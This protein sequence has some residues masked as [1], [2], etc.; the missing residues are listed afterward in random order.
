MKADM[1]IMRVILH[2]LLLAAC[3]RAAEV[4]SWTDH[5]NR[6]VEAR[7]L[8][9]EGETV[10]LEL[11][12]GRKLPF[13]LANLSVADVA[14]A[15]SQG[16]K[17]DAESADGSEKSAPNFAAAWPDRIK[18]GED[19]EIKVVEEDGE[20]KRF[21][22]ESA[23]YRYTCDVRLSK[24]VVKG[25]AVMFEATYLFC[26]S[27]PLGLDG[28]RRDGGK[29][30]I[31]LFEK[32]DDYSK[33]GGPQGTA[34]VFLGG[35]ALV[36]VPLSSLGVRTMGSGYTFDR[37]KSSKTLPHELAHQLTAEA[38]FAPGGMGWFSEGIAEYIAV[39]PYRSGAYSVRNNQKDIIDYVTEYGANGNGGRALGKELQLADLKTYMLQEYERFMENP[40]LNYGSALLIT[41]YFLQMDGDGDAKR[42]KAFL[43]A[44][45]DGTTGGDALAVLLDGRS[46]GQLEKEISKAWK[47]QGVELVFAAAR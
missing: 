43:K 4:R 8:G 9:L 36:L 5:K 45:R 6:S 20:R 25:F 38:Y 32:I 13:P 29:L 19:P 14:F 27:L 24:T 17:G 44:L 15:R 21:V 40:Q 46:F 10:I 30:Q 35:D 18:F 28:G 7:M 2:V 34:G 33:A 42:I 1:N 16:A 37:D 41:Y 3:A 11:K 39:T 26:R 12:D 31:R 23:N 47:R 22:Y